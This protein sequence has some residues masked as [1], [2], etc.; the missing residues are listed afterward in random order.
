[1]TKA[2]K[3]QEK[4]P[5]K[6]LKMAPKKATE[7]T[8]EDG[9]NVVELPKKNPVLEELKA[10]FARFTNLATKSE[11]DAVLLV[12]KWIADGSDQDILALKA[13]SQQ[14]DEDLMNNI[15]AKLG[16]SE[17]ETWKNKVD[18]FLKGQDLVR[19]NKYVSEEVVRDSIAPNGV[20]DMELIDLLLTLDIDVAVNFIDEHSGDG[21]AKVLLNLLQPKIT[22]KILDQMD[23]EESKQYIAECLTFEFEEVDDDFKGF[24]ESLKSFIEKSQKKPFNS[25]IL[26]ML[27]N[28]NPNKEG[29]LYKVLAEENMVKE[30]KTAA[31]ENYPA[32]LIVKLPAE[33]LKA[34]MQQYPP[35]ARILL[36]ASVDEETKD[37]LLGSFAEEG[38]AAR[39]MID[40]EFENIENDNAAQARI[41][42]QAPDIW[43]EF[44]FYMRKLIREDEK[45]TNDIQMVIN[46][47]V[48][49]LCGGNSE[50][51]A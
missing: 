32:D 39:E 28:F 31:M 43:K 12:K 45:Y 11:M 5:A 29:M 40:L 21:Q 30:M 37:L 26:Q 49:E 44:V 13:V 47:W 19:A 23:F 25:K 20:S 41:S 24:K 48:D 50:A 33:F 51:A 42:N 46:E 3:K 18:E 35:A 27:P 38:S 8:T 1:M 22:A 14:L 9:D 16:P 34:A 36:L 2:A 4:Q 7:A 17:R 15:F 10:N 6:V